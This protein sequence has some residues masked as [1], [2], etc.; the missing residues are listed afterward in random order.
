[1]VN[2]M[3]EVVGG[4]CEIPE[5]KPLTYCGVET[6]KKGRAKEDFPLEKSCNFST[7]GNQVKRRVK[8]FQTARIASV[9]A[10]G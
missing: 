6:S 10:K 8:K 3:M 9:E 5:E 7:K 2:A 4:F 1:M